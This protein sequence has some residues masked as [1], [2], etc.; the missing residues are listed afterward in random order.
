MFPHLCYAPLGDRLADLG[1]QRE[2]KPTFG[3]A[4][5]TCRV[6]VAH[7]HG[8]HLRDLDR[9]DPQASVLGLADV[10]ISIA[11]NDEQTVERARI[12]WNTI[13]VSYTFLLHGAYE[14]SSKQDFANAQRK[15]GHSTFAKLL[16]ANAWLP[17]H[18][19]VLHKPE[20]LTLE[21]LPEGFMQD[22]TAAKQLGMRSSA[23]RR[24]AEE[25]NI[26]LEALPALQKDPARALAVLREAGLL[27]D[28]GAERARSAD[29]ETNHKV[30]FAHELA[31]AFSQPG[32]TA[33]RD[34]P[35]QPGPAPILHRGASVR[36]RRFNS[37]ANVSQTEQRA[38]D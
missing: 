28:P 37:N 6:S 14:F 31:E 34:D 4:D 3:K 22:E 30:D 16:N 8:F 13:V 26:P 36:K 33:E 19:G 1:L 32:A 24:F 5:V 2:F 9:F 7:W 18:S 20:E 11:V 25:N 10:L 12:I 38:S 27:P 21:D 17:D 23:A 29:E 35:P 15:E